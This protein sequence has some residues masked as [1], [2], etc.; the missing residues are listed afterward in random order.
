MHGALEWVGAVSPAQ[1]KP[2]L[3]FSGLQE[4]A[5]RIYKHHS[6]SIFSRRL[7]ATPSA[8][9]PPSRSRNHPPR[10]NKTDREVLSRQCLPV[11]ERFSC[12]TRSETKLA[13]A[14]VCLSRLETSSR[15]LVAHPKERKT[16]APGRESSEIIC[17][18]AFRSNP[19]QPH[20]IKPQ[21]HLTHDIA[22]LS[23]LHCCFAMAEPSEITHLRRRL[24][25][26]R[27]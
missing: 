6:R 5:S 25:S 15:V 18:R 3:D 17:P 27:H 9:H 14:P 12:L 22:A 19:R 13:R 24:S 11:T 1:V 10:G 20:L 16:R 7:G 8:T 23:P 26:T 21:P 4:Q 2:C